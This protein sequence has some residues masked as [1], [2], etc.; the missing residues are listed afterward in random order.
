MC[1]HLAKFAEDTGDIDGAVLVC[2]LSKPVKLSRQDRHIVNS[3]KI[4]N[5]C[6][7]IYF[8]III[9]SSTKWMS[10][11][12]PTPPKTLL[13]DLGIQRITCTVT[14]QHVQQVLQAG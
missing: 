13:M 10:K 9:P 1:E 6:Y 7:E 12:L 3:R 5:D 14:M 11:S 4:V 2:L 8:L